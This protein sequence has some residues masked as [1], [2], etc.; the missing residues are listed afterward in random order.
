[1]AYICPFT[2]WVCAANPHSVTRQRQIQ[3]ILFR[4]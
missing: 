4:R 2:G 3:S 1:M